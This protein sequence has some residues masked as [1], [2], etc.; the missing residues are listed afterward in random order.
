[1]MSDIFIILIL[2][3]CFLGHLFLL[4]VYSPV[5]ST[6]VIEVNTHRRSLLVDSHRRNRFKNFML[7]TRRRSCC[8]SLNYYRRKLE[9]VLVVAWRKNAWRIHILGV[10][11]PLRECDSFHSLLELELST[12][13][14]LERKG[15]T[16]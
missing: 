9:E 1:M 10:E 3:Y 11:K 16:L 7:S 12:F 6:A 8:S 2:L 4:E 5:M 13:E 15:L 14:V